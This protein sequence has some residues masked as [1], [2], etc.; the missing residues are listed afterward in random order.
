MGLFMVSSMAVAESNYEVYY[1]HAA[2]RCSNCTNA[3]AWAGEAV[4]LLRES[5][6]DT[7]IVY[8]PKELD[9]NKELADLTGAGR[10]DL[11]CAE[12]RDGKLVRFKNIG[13][14]LKVIHSKQ[15]L[16]ETVVDG[17]VAFSEPSDS[18]GVLKPP[19][20][21]ISLATRANG[22][23]RKIMIYAFTD[24]TANWLDTRIAGSVRT[25]LA[26]GYSAQLREQRILSCAVDMTSG[27]NRVLSQDFNAKSGDYVIALMEGNDLVFY[28]RISRALTPIQETSFTTTFAGTLRQYARYIDTGP[29][30]LTED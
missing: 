24:K 15:V 4:D 21:T 26:T 14:L 13:N 30:T 10:V 12:M 25:I 3:E 29:A 19:K 9:A 11:V 28:D 17:I 2:W 6:P 20:T 18:A 7:D 8:I 5:N 16:L 23:T 22:Q 27:P 1:F